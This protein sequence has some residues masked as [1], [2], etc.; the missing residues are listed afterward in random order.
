MANNS[1]SASQQYAFELNENDV[2]CGRGSGPN[3]RVGN[4]NFRN[5]VLSRKAEYLAAPS[6]DAKGRIAT[7]IVDTIHARGGRFLKKLS[8]AQVKEAG[9]KRGTAVYELADEATVLEKAKQTLR[10]NRAEFVQQINKNNEAGG[11][12]SVEATGETVAQAAAAA[13]AVASAPVPLSAP[14]NNDNNAGKMSASRLVQ[15]HLPIHLSQPLQ[16]GNSMCSAQGSLNPIPLS[17]ASAGLD[18]M[19]RPNLSAR[20]TEHLNKTLFASSNIS[21]VTNPSSIASGNMTSTSNVTN[22]ESQMGSTAMTASSNNSILSMNTAEL[23]AAMGGSLNNSN[24]SGTSAQAFGSLLQ[25]YNSQEEKNLIQQYEQ[26]KAQQQLMLQQQQALPQAFQTNMHFIPEEKQQLQ[27]Q[28]QQREQQLQFQPQ[29]GDQQ[30]QSQQQQPQTQLPEQENNPSDVFASLLRQYNITEDQLSSQPQKPQQYEQQPAPLPASRMQQQQEQQKQPSQALPIVTENIASN[31]D[32]LPVPFEKRLSVDDQQKLLQQFQQ[33]HNQSG[34][35][36]LEPAQHQVHKESIK[37]H[38]PDPL[39]NNSQ[40]STLQMYNDFTAM[41]NNTIQGSS[42]SGSSTDSSLM[43]N[44]PSVSESQKTPSQSRSQEDSLGTLKMNSLN[45][46]QQRAAHLGAHDSTATLKTGSLSNG[47]RQALSQLGPYVDS[48]FTLKKGSYMDY[49]SPLNDL[50]PSKKIPNDGSVEDHPPQPMEVGRSRRRGSR[51][52]RRRSSQKSTESLRLSGVEPADLNDDSLSLSFMT[53][54]RLAKTLDDMSTTSLWTSGT[55]SNT[56]KQSL[57]SRASMKS[58]L[59]CSMLSLMSMSLSEFG[60]NGNLL[61][62]EPSSE[63]D[64]DDSDE[65]DLPNN[66]EKR[67]KLPPTPQVTV[68]K[69][70]DG[71]DLGESVMSLGNSLDEV[72]W[73]K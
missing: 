62:E 52:R 35:S 44:T 48:S 64:H 49:S 32:A 69:K 13:A 28:Q 18:S 51:T 8:S 54:N 46:F 34:V 20:T 24:L 15:Q 70:D 56:L 23:C 45:D 2:L 22:S 41:L 57:T 39:Q 43:I 58:S 42:Q 37:T 1:N 50:Q 4:I 19:Q 26:L 38:T 47:S 55:S 53:A 14:C 67:G 16:N 68:E 21:S 71:E 17:D 73:N 63:N 9:F 72:E 40:K 27:I 59:D 11:G 30:L 12:S 33:L 31:T 61:L 36:Y 65:D 5:L 25:E 60:P 6:R 3:D 10:Q 66:D 29:Q 7:N